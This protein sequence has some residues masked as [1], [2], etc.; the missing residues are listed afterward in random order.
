VYIVFQSLLEFKKGMRTRRAAKGALLAAFALTALHLLA[1][2]ALGQ[3]RPPWWD[4][5]WRYRTLVRVDQGGGS[6][7]VPAASVWV[8]V[9][10][11]ADAEGRD[12]RVIG[13]NGQ[14]V[15]FDVAYAG[16]DQGY[17][18]AFGTQP[19]PG[20][21]AVY[22][23]NPNA[24]PTPHD[25]PHWG[26]VYETR[27]IP[28]NADANT[29]EG[30]SA[31]INT[32]STVYGADFWPRV[33]DGLNPFG[34]ES[35]YLALY[36]GYILCPTAGAYKFAVDSDQSAYL[37][38]DGR[39]V[40]SWPGAH[41]IYEGRK[42]EH[43]GSID[44]TAGVHAFH[45]VHFSYGSAR[46]CMAAWIPPGKQWWEV[47]PPTAFPRPLIGQVYDTE[48]FRQTICADFTCQLNGYLE[49][50]EARVV[51]VQFASVSFSG[52][53]LIRGYEWDFGDGQTSTDPRPAHQY[54]SPGIYSATLRVT[55][56]SG[57]RA[58]VTKRVLA[59]PVYQD[60]NFTQ[61]KMQDVLKDIGDYRFDR[62]PTACLL[63]AWSFFGEASADEKA[64]EAARQLHAR[65]ADLKPDQ[66]YGVAMDLGR[67]YQDS[68]HAKEAEECFQTAL[69]AA[70]ESDLA[71]RFEARFALC[72]LHFLRMND[73]ER[74]RAEYQKLREDFPKADP[75]RRREALIRI[76]DTYRSE[77]KP[78]EALKAY[79][80]AESDPAFLP[81]QPRRL[82]EAAQLEAAESYLRTGQAEEAENRLDD[83]LAHYPTLRLDGR[84]AALRVQDANYLPI[85]HLAAA[86]ACA[87]LGLA[88]QAA[89][90][91]GKIVDQFPEAPEAPE[92]QA[93]LRKLA[94]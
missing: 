13:P 51:N 65:R 6:A 85:V 7:G 31:A 21:Y 68:D 93:A 78:D 5:R 44:L 74:A 32:Y 58:A 20:F 88:D 61:R 52:Q 10:Q 46:R 17:L 9:R 76:G 50:G 16:P 36:H 28:P 63:G 77:G 39:L 4:G 41:N 56:T 75:G 12:I 45:Y 90:H 30:A 92:A 79:K 82:V 18:L 87:E 49:A 25:A 55:S 29:Y 62:L 60:L 72:D 73:P 42:G 48:E 26:L 59:R 83:L 3:E 54:L 43:S 19:D 2:P 81:E 80:E 1:A 15:P 33:Y 66:L 86:E 84:A 53:D 94:G 71:K 24:G 27:R 69:D 67:R 11:D 89:D 38:V 91:Y 47:I 34:P 14:R 35:D 57:L 37:S 8:H 64:M 40:A 70:P 23:G 22:Y